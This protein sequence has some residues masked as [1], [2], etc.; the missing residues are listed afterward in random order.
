MSQKLHVSMNMLEEIDKMYQIFCS[1]NGFQHKHY[2]QFI[3]LESPQYH[4]FN[5]FLIAK[6][7]NSRLLIIIKKNL[8]DNFFIDLTQPIYLSD[9]D[10]VKTI[11]NNRALEDIISAL[12]KILNK[13]INNNITNNIIFNISTKTFSSVGIDYYYKNVQIRL[14]MGPTIYINDLVFVLNFILLKEQY[15]ND[16]DA[17]ILQIIKFLIFL[18]NKQEDLVT[19]I[20]LK[21][22]QEQLN[23][24]IYKN[25]FF[26]TYK[27]LII[28]FYSLI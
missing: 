21:L 12:E 22:N 16:H 7:N 18:K 26:E 25:N 9:I 13:L 20:K 15:S 6:Q 28:E 3:K 23:L 14:N 17:L 1:H 5:D 8:T 4:S 10:I 24:S 19:Y 27:K 11:K 2:I